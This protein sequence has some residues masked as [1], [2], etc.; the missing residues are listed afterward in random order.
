MPKRRRRE[1]EQLAPAPA[2]S[3]RSIAVGCVSALLALTGGIATFFLGGFTFS[4]YLQMKP[5]QATE[6]VQGTL[7]P[8]APV[9]APSAAIEQAAPLSAAPAVAVQEPAV[10]DATVETVV[11]KDEGAVEPLATTAAP[12]K[13]A[14]KLEKCK[15]V[16]FVRIQKT[17]S[18]TFGQDIMAKMCSNNKQTCGVSWNR[19]ARGNAK[20]SLPLSYYHLDF[21][22]ASRLL[23]GEGRSCLVTFL[24][25][26]VERTLS[27]FF[28]LR[29]KHRQF[30]QFDQWDVH[31]DDFAAINSILDIK[32]V[33]ESFQR[34]LHHPGNPS[35]NRQAL[36][37]LGFKRVECNQT[38]CGGD[39]CICEKDS[40]GNPAKAYDWDANAD[41]LLE[42]AKQQLLKLDA[43]G[44]TDCFE[45]S[46]EILSPLLGWS[47]KD[48]L[49]IAKESH[50]MHVWKPTMEKA[51]K[52]KP[53]SEYE[54]SAR[55]LRQQ[56][57]HAGAR[58]HE[59]GGG[60]MRRLS[61]NGPGSNF[62][63]EFISPDVRKDILEV[64]SID[65][66]LV[67]FAREIYLQQ[68]GKPCEDKA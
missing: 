32:D 40:P 12:T 31:Q 63:R 10:A 20:C 44:I 42:R 29:E 26:P 35:R 41:E 66:E 18:T 9:P 21:S 3:W 30:L 46:V 50:A 4:V 52:I 27:E 53:F 54:F 56:Q 19:C 17:A 1:P 33:S 49:K 57:S 14:Q 7:T 2:R 15:K 5:Q 62:W 8:G 45:E 37:L 39:A 24:R 34:Y 48:A 55:R 51:R 6:G 11:E 23:Q 36:Y 61:F 64:N 67:R 60:L 58:S 68:Y 16:A 22:Y 13:A 65:D 38:R 59:Q 25:D 28:M 43:F 47:A